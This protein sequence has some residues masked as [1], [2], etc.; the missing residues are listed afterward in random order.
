MQI[1]KLDKIYKDIGEILVRVKEL[2]EIDSAAEAFDY[3]RRIEHLMANFEKTTKT[4]NE[5][6][7]VK[8]ILIKEISG[9]ESEMETLKLE[10]Y[11]IS[12]RL[13]DLLKEKDYLEY[14]L[15]KLKNKYKLT[16]A[17]L[18]EI[19]N[20]LSAR[21]EEYKEHTKANNCM[22]KEVEDLELAIILEE[23]AIS[24]KRKELKNLEIFSIR[25]ETE[26]R[27]LDKLASQAILEL[28]K[29]VKVREI[30]EDRVN[31]GPSNSIP[32]KVQYSNNECGSLNK[33]E[34]TKNQ[35]RVLTN[36]RAKLCSSL[37]NIKIKRIITQQMI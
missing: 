24:E 34:Y 27:K 26:K 5:N 30:I 36:G 7:L 31:N 29:K 6:K 21:Y 23:N 37:Q 8:S 25:K 35:N 22:R 18:N 12:N 1:K 9:I 32:I 20:N 28:K 19:K 17:E 15:N 14:E 2:T 16:N 11:R 4:N 10:F 3:S 33:E 13:S